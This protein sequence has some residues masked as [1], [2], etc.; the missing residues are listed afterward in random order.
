MSLGFS[1]SNEPVRRTL[2]WFHDLVGTHDFS[3]I[4]RALADIQVV[5]S[6]TCPRQKARSIVFTKLS[7]RVIDADDSPV[8]IE[9]CEYAKFAVPMNTCAI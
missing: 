4:R 8:P 2:N 5:C 9:N 7:P 6:N 3:I 1:L